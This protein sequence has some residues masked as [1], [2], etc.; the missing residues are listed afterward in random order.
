MW[1]RGSSLVC[2]SILFA[3]AC[4]DRQPTAVQPQQTAQAQYLAPALQTD[5]HTVQREPRPRFAMRVAQRASTF[6][7]AFV[8]G[9]Q[10]VV[11][12]TDLTKASEVRAAVASE[13]L[14]DPHGEL[15]V[16][17]VPMRYSLAKLDQFEAVF[18]A[19]AKSFGI[20]LSGISERD[21]AVRLGVLSADQR[22]AILS[23]AGRSGVPRD[24]IVVE[25]VATPT[26][27]RNL[28]S[29]IRPVQGGVQ[30]TGNFTFNGAHEHP[31]CTLG[32]NVKFSVNLNNR[33]QLSAAHCFEPDQPGDFGGLIGAQVSQPDSSVS[34]LM[35]SV[36]INPSAFTH[37]TNANCPLGE[38]CRFSDAALAQITQSSVTWDFGGIAQPDAICSL[39]TIFCSTNIAATNNRI[40]LSGTLALLQGDTV[41]RVG[42]TTGEG[43]GV[44]T[45][46]CINVYISSDNGNR[47]CSAQVSGAIGAGDSGG[48]V[49]FKN[50]TRGTY[51]LEGLEF[52]ANGN[53]VY[54][55]SPWA[56][57]QSEVSE[58]MGTF[59]VH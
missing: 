51:F 52:G 32:L 46:A 3:A 10:L 50:T 7:G 31:V 8:N 38:A 16:R 22:P 35:G 4:S 6:A 26:L 13:L 39:P 49:M 57:I 55:F 17:V 45:N 14:N 25:V 5:F 56:S 19:Q 9:R 37:S 2:G 21:N 29:G 23:A 18:R 54:F 11:G 44:V 47:L 15:P 58:G 59:T 41:Y 27:T 28:T 30:I 43:I 20:V 34:A 40:Q 12:T 36:I 53:T 48:P 33:Y 1:F 42:R 24:A